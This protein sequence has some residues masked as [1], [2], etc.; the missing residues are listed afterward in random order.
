MWPE[1]LNFDPDRGGE[2]TESERL[3]DQC[4]RM[5][6]ED[7]EEDTR[8]KTTR[9]RAKGQKFRRLQVVVDLRQSN[10]FAF[11]G[12]WRLK[13]VWSPGLCHLAA[14]P[15]L[16]RNYSYSSTRQVST[17]ATGRG[18]ETGESKA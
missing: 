6:E 4:Q 8:G 16:S 11:A 5:K 3:R 17:S 2:C 13:G 18:W 7:E 12:A 1:K 10:Y 14:P 9:E 15:R